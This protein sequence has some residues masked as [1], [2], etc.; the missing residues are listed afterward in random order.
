[1]HPWL[2]YPPTVELYMAGEGGK[3]M[4]HMDVV[5]HELCIAW[6]GSDVP[7]ARRWKGVLATCLTQK[8]AVHR[9]EGTTHLSLN[10]PTKVGPPPNSSIQQILSSFSRKVYSRFGVNWSLPF[11][12]QQTSQPY[13]QHPPIHT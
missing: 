13:F 6:H 8:R 10:L 9:R 11:S 7:P 5:C 12:S 4:R 3:E 1:M 2:L